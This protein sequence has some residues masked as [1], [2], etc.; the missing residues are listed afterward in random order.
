MRFAALSQVGRSVPIVVSHALIC[1]LAINSNLRSEE[2]AEDRIAEF[3]VHLQSLLDEPMECLYERSW[4]AEQ[5]ETTKELTVCT[6]SQ[7]L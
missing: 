1:I 5:R 7:W 6:G 4:V 2:N 3:L